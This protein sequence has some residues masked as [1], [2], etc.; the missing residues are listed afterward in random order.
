MCYSVCLL[1]QLKKKEWSLQLVRKC[2]LWNLK[3]GTEFG[4]FEVSIVI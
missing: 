3:N 4:H 2:E 1:V